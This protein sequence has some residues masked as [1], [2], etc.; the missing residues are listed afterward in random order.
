LIL[1]ATPIGNLDDASPRL[2]AALASAD[3]VYAEDTRRSRVLL[4]HLGVSAVV[5]SYFVGNERSRSVELG[6][7]LEEGDTVALITDAGTPAIADPGL[8][9]VRAAVDADAEITIVPGPSA[10][11]AAV[12]VSGLSGDRFVFEG[13]LPRK[14]GPRRRRLEELAGEERT[15]VLFAAPSRVANDLSAIA[16]ILGGDREVVVARELTKAHEEVYRGSADQVARRWSEDV[17]PRGEF[18]LVVAGAP[19]RDQPIGQ[20]LAEVDARVDE[21]RSLSEVVRDVAESAG[22]SRRVLYQAALRARDDA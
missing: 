3:I 5:R 10:V 20:L 19:D 6:T 2:A 7:R 13:F 1:C 9:A 12:A 11:S 8:S 21:G 22:V 18:T 16:E 4:D 15:I 17:E 14:A